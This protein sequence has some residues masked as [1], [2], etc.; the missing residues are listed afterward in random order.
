M[1]SMT[2]RLGRS[3]RT[4]Q[5]GD[6]RFWRR[7]DVVGFRI[8][9]GRLQKIVQSATLECFRL[10]LLSCVNVDAEETEHHVPPS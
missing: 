7:A 5:T 2:Q 9:T 8:K 1:F 4:D 3:R 6:Q 10:S